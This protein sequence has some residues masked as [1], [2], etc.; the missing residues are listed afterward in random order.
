[1]NSMKELHLS[2]LNRLAC[3]L[4]WVPPWPNCD[5]LFVTWKWYLFCHLPTDS[6]RARN[7]VQDAHSL[8][9]CRH[10]NNPLWEINLVKELLYKNVYVAAVFSRTPQVPK[11][12]E[13]KHFRYAL[14]YFW[15]D[16][17]NSRPNTVSPFS[18]D[19]GFKWWETSVF[20]SLVH[21]S[22]TTNFNLRKVL[23]S[24]SIILIL[25]VTFWGFV[26]IFSPD[27]HTTSFAFSNQY[28]MLALAVRWYQSCSKGAEVFVG[29]LLW[30]RSPLG[31][32]IPFLCSSRIVAGFIYLFIWDPEETATALLPEKVTIFSETKLVQI[33]LLN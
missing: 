25:Q 17:T 32:H 27:L 21:F 7:G 31:V 26:P 5:T 8:F 14:I 18:C 1:M 16:E 10:I 15:K 11:W 3:F 22:D 13:V 9:G 19:W 2:I 29:H 23:I 30:L 4:L 28:V 12:T 24:F 33:F 20:I 6:E